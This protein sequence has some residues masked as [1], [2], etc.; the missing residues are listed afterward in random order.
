[1][2]PDAAKMLR[3]VAAWHRDNGAENWL[4]PHELMGYDT[5]GK[6]AERLRLLAKRGYLERREVKRMFSGT[7]R[8]H[9]YRITAEG[10]AALE[11]ENKDI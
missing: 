10:K 4:Q 6:R 8:L 2:K 1:M 9:E 5:I 7:R 3:S 11:R